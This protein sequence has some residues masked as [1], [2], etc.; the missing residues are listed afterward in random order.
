MN[1]LPDIIKCEN[2]AACEAETFTCSLR[3]PDYLMD[4]AAM[5]GKWMTWDEIRQKLN[6]EADL[7][8]DYGCGS[9]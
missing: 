7:L 8:Q 4:I 3:P 9:V 5:D 1:S 6:R 2:C